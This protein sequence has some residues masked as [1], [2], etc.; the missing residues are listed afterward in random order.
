LLILPLVSQFKNLHYVSTTPFHLLPVWATPTPS[1]SPFTDK[2][3]GK[4][5]KTF[6][7]DLKKGTEIEDI[8]FLLSRHQKKTKENKPFLL[9]QLQDKTGIIIGRLFEGVEQYAEIKEKSFVLVR[10]RVDEYREELG[11]VINELKPI[12]EEEITRED[13][14]RRSEKDLDE[15]LN[16][17]R[18]FIDQID[19][20]FCRQLL[21]SFFSDTDFLKRFKFAP[22]AKRAHQA[23]LGGLLEHTL[24]LIKICA[25]AK[26]I[27]PSD[28]DFPLLFTACILHDIGKIRE[29][30]YD[31]SIDFSTPGK[32]IGHIVLGYEMVK[33]KIEE[34]KDFPENLKNK[35]LHL[36]LSSHGEKEYGSPVVPKI[37]EGIFLHYID[38]LDSKMAMVRELKERTKEE[39]KEWSEYHKLL[40]TE[41][42]FG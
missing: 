5:K 41:I 28:F 32:L 12:G 2:S 24:Y 15:M 13:F 21:V 6:I 1:P 30:E 7:K 33:E 31:V 27:Y 20:P 42:Y 39:G 37:P 19:E 22:A 35:L 17:I 40:E 10:G 9:C 14:I 4:M 18:R 11:I 26:E 29:Y 34:I 25:S 16:E 36:I 23:Y 38:N 3:L 8:F